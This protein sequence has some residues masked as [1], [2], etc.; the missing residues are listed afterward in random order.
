MREHLA[1]AHVAPLGRVPMVTQPHGSTL[2]RRHRGLGSP[3]HCQRQ[4]RAPRDILAHMAAAGSRLRSV[5][6]CFVRPKQTRWATAHSVVRTQCHT[7]KFFLKKKHENCRP[8][9]ASD[10]PAAAGGRGELPVRGRLSPDAGRAD[11]APP[12]LWLCAMSGRA[13]GDPWKPVKSLA[14]GAG[15]GCITKTVTAPLERARILLQIQGMKG[16][17]GAD[18]KVRPSHAVRVRVRVR[19]SLMCAPRRGLR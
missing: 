8:R 14:C 12:A 13:E 9:A 16:L 3:C 1:Q 10:A 2:L 6:H 19:G 11:A 18:R 7:N 5:C 4:L 17:V 15:S